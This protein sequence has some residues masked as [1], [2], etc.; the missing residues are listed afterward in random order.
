[1]RGRLD[2]RLAIPFLLFACSRTG[3]Y[4]GEGTK[5]AGVDASLPPPCELDEDCASDDLCVRAFCEATVGA[6]A[7]VVRRC[8]TEPV[9]CDDGDAC[10][11]DRCE[12][13]DG[14]CAHE[15]TVDADRD[16]FVGRAPAGLAASCGGM[17]CDDENP[18]VFPGARESCDGLDND[19]DGSLDDGSLYA[20]AAAPVR[21]ASSMASSQVSGIAFDGSTYG[22][23]YTHRSPARDQA[24]FERLDPNGQ[25]LAGPALVSEI[26]ADSYS[27]SLAYS[28]TSFLTAWADARQA[29]NYEIYSTRFDLDANKL[30]PDLR[31]TQAFDFSVSPVLRHTGEE[32]IVIWVDHR[33]QDTGGG[34]AI[35]GRRLSDSGEPLSEEI[36]LTDVDEDAESGSFDVGDERLGLAYVVPGEPL[37]DGSDPPTAVRFK[38]FDRTLADPSAPIELGT[39]AQEPTVQL[40][41]ERFVVAWHTGSVKGTWGPAV[42]AATLDANGVILA[43][44]AITEGDTHAKHRTLVSLGDRVLVVWAATPAEGERFQ[45][46][47]ET[48]RVETLEVSTPRQLLVKSA[49]G[50]DLISPN[51]VR[52]P[53]GDIGIV[54]D[55]SGTYQAFF[56]RLACAIPP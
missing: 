39:D 19:C 17:D 32:Y 41:G 1:M 40:A 38:T 8:R 12:P 6:E 30:Q 20:T 42:I 44:G 37:P 5:D 34:N 53:D 52:G 14:R 16:G 33:D 43:S 9:S 27:G 54:Y 55:E 13:A 51:A 48:L 31:L 2:T 35:Y 18:L 47:Y 22:V 49:V 4:L 50:Q 36:R 23:V 45:L 25:V 29:G 7:G 26:N 15:R 11:L 46:F 28:G 56:L 24:Y 21:L 10:S 3:L